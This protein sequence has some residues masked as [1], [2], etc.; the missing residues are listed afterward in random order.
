MS[1][2]SIVDVTEDLTS[3]LEQSFAH[4]TA[5]WKLICVSSTALGRSTFILKAMNSMHVIFG[6]INQGKYEIQLL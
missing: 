1:T 3:A 2:Q 4:G 5:N 6:Q